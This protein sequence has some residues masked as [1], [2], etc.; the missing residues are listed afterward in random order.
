[1]YE[2]VT[3]EFCMHMCECETRH[4]KCSLVKFLIVLTQALKSRSARR[5]T[6]WFSRIQ[7]ACNTEELPTS[8]YSCTTLLHPRVLMD[9]SEKGWPLYRNVT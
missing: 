4:H 1:M 7:N 9:S 8:A 5:S 6:F 3:Y 2:C